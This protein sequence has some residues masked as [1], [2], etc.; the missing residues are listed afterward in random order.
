MPAGDTD[1]VNEQMQKEMPRA[2]QSLER[3]PGTR[4]RSGASSGRGSHAADPEIRGC[5]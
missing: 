3:C 1:A 2:L 5:G 4:R